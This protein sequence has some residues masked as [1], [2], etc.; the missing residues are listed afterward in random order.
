MVVLLVPGGWVDGEADSRAGTGHDEG[1]VYLGTATLLDVRVV[2]GGVGGGFEGVEG[3]VDLDAGVDLIA[4][5]APARVLVLDVRVVGALVEGGVRGVVDGNVVVN[6]SG[7]VGVVALATPARTLVLDVR[8]VGALVG[9]GFEGVDL[10]ALESAATAI[11]GDIHGDPGTWDRHGGGS[12]S[13]GCE[14][15]DHGYEFHLGW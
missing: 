15:G 8:V 5:A 10:I 4:L 1:F 2:G 6:V 12:G 7:R 9:G 13:C 3:G 14:A 11:V